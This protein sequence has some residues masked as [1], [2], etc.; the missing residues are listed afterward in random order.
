MHTLNPT[1]KA[2]TKKNTSEILINSSIGYAIE[3]QT[4]SVEQAPQLK[5]EVIDVVN[6]YNLLDRISYEPI[7]ILLAFYKSNSGNAIWDIAYYILKHFADSYKCDCS[8]ESLIRVIRRNG[9]VLD[10]MPHKINQLLLL[11]IIV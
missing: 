9:I 11:F 3:K 2:S 5:K 1:P 4:L 10:W 6:K 7:A 8:D